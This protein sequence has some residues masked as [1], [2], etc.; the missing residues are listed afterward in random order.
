MS[1]SSPSKLEKWTGSSFEGFEPVRAAR[2]A[3]LCGIAHISTRRD[4]CLRPIDVKLCEKKRGHFCSK[5]GGLGKEG[6]LHSFAFYSFANQES[7]Q[8]HHIFG[9]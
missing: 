2:K 5:I 3:D 8:G 1:K 4:W 6:R 9:Q 7:S